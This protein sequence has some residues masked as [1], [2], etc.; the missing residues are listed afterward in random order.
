MKISIYRDVSYDFH[1][2]P[3]VRYNLCVDGYYLMHYVTDSYNKK[4]ERETIKLLMKL[5]LTQPYINDIL[6]D[7]M[8]KYVAQ[9]NYLGKLVHEEVDTE[10]VKKLRMKLKMKE[11]D[12]DFV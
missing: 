3:H 10:I 8:D 12:Q 6:Y 2:H 9:V 1:A 11:I 7:R 4:K 5:V